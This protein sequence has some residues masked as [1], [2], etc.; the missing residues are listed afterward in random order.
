MID[1]SCAY[2]ETP[3]GLLEVRGNDRGVRSVQFVEEKRYKGDIH[4]IVLEML[5]Q[6]D[7]YFGGNLGAFHSLPLA[8]ECTTF[9]ESVWDGARNIPYGE[10]RTYGELAEEI[11]HKKAARAVGTALSMNPLLLIVPCHRILPSTGKVGEFAAGS[12]R[13]EWL[14]EHERE[15]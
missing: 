7:E 13:K 9:Q 8:M 11:G 6:V 12:W 14:L 4:S 1:L 2:T 5:G 10:T 3:I 15:D